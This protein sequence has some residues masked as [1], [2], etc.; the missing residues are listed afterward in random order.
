MSREELKDT[1]PHVCPITLEEIECQHEFTHAG[2]V[3]NIFALYTYLT[4]SVY[5][6]NPVT[7]TTFTL[8]ELQDLESGIKSLCGDDSIAY[9]EDTDCTVTSRV[10]S[11]ENYNYSSTSVSEYGDTST[12]DLS[13]EYHVLQTN[14]NT[15]RLLVQVNVSLQPNSSS[16]SPSSS[17]GSDT[18]YFDEESFE[19]A[20][21]DNL[22]PRRCYPSVVSMFEDDERSSKMKADLDILQYLSYDCLDTLTQITSILSDRRFHQVVWEQTSPIILE[23]VS[24]VVDRAD[25]VDVEVTYLNCWDNY[26]TL[27]LRTLRN[28]YAETLADMRR[29]DPGEAEITVRSHI[30]V[31][32]E[33]TDIDDERRASLILYLRSLL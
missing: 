9:T 19:P 4:K 24:T 12:Q 26:R 23:T 7:R 14:Q 32:E 3:F 8:Q 17:S 28:R 27:L 25:G 13:L 11:D 6:Q 30:S 22:P 10:S 16:A 15:E 18:T 5:F 21:L 2:I 33:D 29:V 20:T 1:G 31:V